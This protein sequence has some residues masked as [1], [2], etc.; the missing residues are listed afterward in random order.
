[1]K[2]LTIGEILVEIVAT[3]KGNG[4]LE[5]QPLIG[6][7][8]SG[9]PAIFIDQAGKL[10]FPCVIL[11]RV[12]N[13]D[14]GTLNIQRLN[15]DGVDV[16]G[17]EVAIGETTG[18]AFVRYRNDGNRNF[19]FNILHSAC[20][21]LTLNTTAKAI[22][23]ECD[24]LHIMGSALITPNLQELV[25]WAVKN[26]KQRGGKISFDPNLRNELINQSGLTETLLQ[27]L[28]KTD[29]FLPSG[30]E[31]FIFTTAQK[32]SEAI[33]ELLEKGISEIILK[34][35][36]QGASFFSKKERIDISPI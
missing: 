3:T 25:L 34:R 11:S 36:N 4:F 32:E 16:K 30:N 7:F 20:G 13:D 15:K 12:G 21:K 19:I 28:E 14:F 18:S 2:L 26:I 1:M 24:A 23:E 5:A 10:G 6:P 22:I 31:M 9:S 35:G 27:V 8:P 29:I 17:I 33:D